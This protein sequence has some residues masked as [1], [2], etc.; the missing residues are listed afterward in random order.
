[1]SDT[2]PAEQMRDRARRLVRRGLATLTAA[3]VTGL[4]AIPAALH[5]NDRYLFSGEGLEDLG[6]IAVIGLAGVLS[7]VGLTLVLANHRL[8][9]QPTPVAIIAGML[10]L[11]AAT[12]SVVAAS[13][14]ANRV[15]C[16]A[17]KPA[18]QKHYEPGQILHDV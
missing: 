13:H 9:Q 2:N 16:P 5:A 10:V 7:T 3:A 8:A 11:A 17:D 1:M 14:A 4:L 12:G 6:L 18:C 15:H